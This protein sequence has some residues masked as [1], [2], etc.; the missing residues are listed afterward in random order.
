MILKVYENGKRRMVTIV[1]PHIKEDS[2]YYIYKEISD[3]DLW[4]KTRDGD[5]YIGMF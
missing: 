2:N 5:N 3:Q 4:T 1:D